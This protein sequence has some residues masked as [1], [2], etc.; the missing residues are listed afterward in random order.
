MRPR[1]AKSEADVIAEVGGGDGWTGMG[2]GWD[3]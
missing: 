1:E 3:V 2:R